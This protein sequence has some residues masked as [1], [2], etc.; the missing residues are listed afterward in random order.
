MHPL[1]GSCHC[2]NIRVELTLSRE[3][4]EYTPRACDCDFCRKH[5]AAYLSDA[6]GS[7][8]IHV[9]AMERLQRY[10]QGSGIAQMLVCGHCGVLVGGL[11]AEDDVCYAAV[12][13][14]I[15]DGGANFAASQP[16][17]PQA[18]PD[19]GKIE[20]WKRLWF[21]HVQLDADCD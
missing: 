19:A 1:T 3:P 17:S 13:V 20:R 4:T 9:E 12:N 6:D 16:A 7:L 21:A 10:R 8:S 18:L 15:I 14:R 2:G 5:G 11:Y